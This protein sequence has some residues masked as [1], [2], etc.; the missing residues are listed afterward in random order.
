GSAK[1]RLTTV[2]RT[3]RRPT[4]SPTYR[5][6]QSEN[7]AHDLRASETATMSNGKSH[8]TAVAVVPPQ[9]YW[10]P[11]QA[12]RRVH[13]RQIGRWMPHINLLYPFV[14]PDRLANSFVSIT[15]ACAAIGPFTITLSQFRS[16]HHASGRATV[17]L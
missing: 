3:A 11:I 16:F 5:K 13:D 1:S 8:H 12:I 15:E 9:D 7:T 10:E 6:H 14:A 17:W 4:Q 2:K